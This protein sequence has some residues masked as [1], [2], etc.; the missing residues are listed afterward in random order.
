MGTK[1]L[2]EEVGFW[3]ELKRQFGFS[4]CFIRFDYPVR[5]QP[6][7]VEM[8]GYLPHPDRPRP[9]A[10]FPPGLPSIL[11][12]LQ[13]PA[14]LP[15]S[16]WDLLSSWL[17]DICLWPGEYM[18]PLLSRLEPPGAGLLFVPQL[19]DPGASLHNSAKIPEGQRS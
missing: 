3:S 8:R 5:K 18:T 9:F 12:F 17:S 15:V 10:F 1:K 6:M 4:V 19:G 16:A 7:W 14:P 2:R 13:G 11:S